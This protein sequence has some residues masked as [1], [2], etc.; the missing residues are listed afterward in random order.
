MKK[1]FILFFLFGIINCQ[2]QVDTILPYKNSLRYDPLPA[3]NSTFMLG[4]E[5]YCTP[6]SSLLLM[7]S[8]MYKEGD[9][10]AHQGFIFEVQYRYHVINKVSNNGKSV[11]SYYAAPYAVAKF[12][13][14][15]DVYTKQTWNGSYYDTETIGYTDEF[16]AFSGG[17]I[18]GSEIT[19]AKKLF[20]DFY[21]G[22]GIRTAGTNRND[23]TPM[24]PGFK[25]IAAKIGFNIGVRF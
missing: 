17:I 12:F 6:V 5:Q 3:V 2:A 24:D 22:G 8:V 18:G 15:E 19:F 9:N 4:F 16:N 21:L 20:L 13:R 14:I 10:Y 23:D 7:P 1:I 11:I 25:G